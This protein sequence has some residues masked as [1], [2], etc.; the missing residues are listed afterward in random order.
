M[1]F[2]YCSLEILPGNICSKETH[3][4]DSNIHLNPSIT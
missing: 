1:K 2:N 3:T 4:G